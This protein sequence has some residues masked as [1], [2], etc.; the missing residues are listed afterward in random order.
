MKIPT[1]ALIFDR[2]KTA[3]ETF[4][5]IVEIRLTYD[6]KQKYYSTGVKILPKQ[7][8]KEKHVIKH[9]DST[10]LNAQIDSLYNAI[11]KFITTIALRQ[12]IFSFSALHAE[13]DKSKLN[14]SFWNFVNES[15][16]N[17]TD[18]SEN[19]KKNHRK[20]SNIMEDF[21]IFEK[22]S[23]LTAENI[24][25][26]DRL[27]H[28]RNYTQ[29]TIH[30]YHKFLKIY[31][32][33]ALRKGFIS[34]DPYLG[35]SIDRGKSALRKYLTMEEFEQ[36]RN[37][38]INSPCIERTKD[39]FLFQCYTGMAYAEIERF[40]SSLIVERNG[41]SIY[42]A[43]RKKTG[44]GFYIV[45]LPEA[46]SILEKYENKLPVISNQKYNMQL[47]TLASISEIRKDLTSHMA[48]H[49]FAVN[50]L[51]RG[52]PIE[53]VSRMLGHTNIQTTQIYA[54]IMNKTIEEAFDILK[55]THKVK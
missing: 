27:L 53:V 52:I 7:W 51:N 20:L 37:S 45:L 17:K 2:K 18:I 40:D 32:R 16:D 25:E 55:D 14:D 54:K 35:I 13:I 34:A 6:R 12:E 47:K 1:I 28:K 5:G 36:I 50:A 30:S 19:T 4:G 31:V 24:L 49:T 9:P 33:E 38:E 15:R 42:T 43:E 11:K 21:K 29:T 22:F 8:D 46:L 39:L 48:R 44:S 3:S 41:R 10:M 23:D 26:F